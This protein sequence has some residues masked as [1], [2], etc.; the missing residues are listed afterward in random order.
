M[1]QK[2]TAYPLEQS[3]YDAVMRYWLKQIQAG[4][5]KLGKIKAMNELI[6]A[7][8]TAEGV[9]AETTAPAPT[10]TRRTKSPV[11]A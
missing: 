1:M 4:R 6:L 8:A 2:T 3:S 9:E 11:P 10:K 5:V 7:G